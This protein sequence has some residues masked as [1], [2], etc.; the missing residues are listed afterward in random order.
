MYF[1]VL[2]HFNF[3]CHLCWLLFVRLFLLSYNYNISSSGSFVI[4]MYIFYLCSVAVFCQDVVH[5]GIFFSQRRSNECALRQEWMKRKRTINGIW[6]DSSF[7]FFFDSIAALWQ[8]TPF[9]VR[10]CVRKRGYWITNG[11][12]EQVGCIH[13]PYSIR[14]YACV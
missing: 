10:G 11:V 7:F 13:N 12:I 5:S 14:F 6:F 1:N 4:R 2:I 3:I 9:T 8:L